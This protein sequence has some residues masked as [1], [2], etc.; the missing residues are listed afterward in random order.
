M[1][2]VHPIDDAHL[3]L[4]LIQ[5][6]L[7][8]Q[9]VLSRHHFHLEARAQNHTSLWT[10]SSQRT[11][12]QHIPQHR[13]SSTARLPSSSGPGGPSSNPRLFLNITCPPH[14]QTGQMDTDPVRR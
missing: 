7:G 8:I 10:T 14:Q 1:V 5:S 11:F 12:L 9:S 3:R 2:V 13:T 6:V 4:A